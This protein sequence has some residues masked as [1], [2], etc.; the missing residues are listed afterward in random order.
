MHNQNGGPIFTIPIVAAALT[1]AGAYDIVGLTAQ[2]SGRL[3]IIDVHLTFASTQFASGSALALQFLRG[4]TA[5]STGAAI[6]PSNVKGWSG[7]STAHFTVTG[8][9]TTP[10]STASAVQV[11]AN[12]FDANGSFRYRPDHRE[13]R[14]TLAVSQRLHLRSTTPSIAATLHGTITVQDTGKWLGS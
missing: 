6:L 12:A 8:P 13:E 4:S 11:Y 10:V 2:S 5:A 1:T 3:E 9:S 14:I 7:A